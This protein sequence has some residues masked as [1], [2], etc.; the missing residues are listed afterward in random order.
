MLKEWTTWTIT[1]IVIMVAVITGLAISGC[2]EHVTYNVLEPV[3]SDKPTV[4]HV[5]V[6]SVNRK[7]KPSLITHLTNSSKR[8][9]TSLM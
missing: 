4:E 9:Q 1:A 5:I 2:G 8:Q 7:A 3:V 6:P